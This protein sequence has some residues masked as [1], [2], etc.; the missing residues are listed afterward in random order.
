[1]RY[2]QRQF[3]K[4]LVVRQHKTTSVVVILKIIDWIIWFQ[5]VLVMPQ[6]TC[7]YRNIWAQSAWAIWKTMQ[8]TTSSEHFD[9]IDWI[10]CKIR[11]QNILVKQQ[12]IHYNIQISECIS[13]MINNS[14][15]HTNSK[16]I[17]DA[18]DT[19][20]ERDI[21]MFGDTT[22]HWRIVHHNVLVTNQHGNVQFGL[23]VIWQTVRY[24][25]YLKGHSQRKKWGLL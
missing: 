10:N 17:C 23:F 5:N 19:T 9:H 3:G 13:D 1:M 20:L 15:E 18:M 11:I 7:I 25:Y 4:I 24:S 22:I 16:C 6:T 21:I 12:T 14:L 8:Y 2:I